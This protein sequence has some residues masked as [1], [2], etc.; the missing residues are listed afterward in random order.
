VSGGVGG[1]VAELAGS[2]G[3]GRILG[4][5]RCSPP[6]GSPAASRINAYIAADGDV[7]DAVKTQTQG[8][9]ADVVFD[10]VGGLM[11]ETAVRCLAHKGRLIEI[12]ATGRQRVEFDLRDF[13]HNES[14]L[15]GADS[16]KLGLVE[17]AAILGRLAPLFDA[18]SL[19]APV[20]SR[21]LPLER[22]VEAYEAVAAGAQGRVVIEPSVANSIL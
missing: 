1:A 22:G 16:R 10:A 4:V 15:F 14:R 5:D 18:G 12:A 21:V 8:H 7:A 13:Y 17:S 2:L 20:I 3:A 6:E 19:K 9:G 11:F